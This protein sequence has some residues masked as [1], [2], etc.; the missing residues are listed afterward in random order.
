MHLSLLCMC[1]SVFRSCLLWIADPTTIHRHRTSFLPQ[2]DFCSRLRCPRFTSCFLRR[3]EPSPSPKKHIR[4][5]HS[6]HPFLLPVTG[7]GMGIWCNW[8]KKKREREKF[9]WRAS[10]KGLPHRSRITKE[11]QLLSCGGGCIWVRCANSHSHP[12]ARSDWPIT[13]G[14][15]ADKWKEPDFGDAAESLV[16]PQSCLISSP[17][18]IWHN[19]FSLLFKPAE[20][21][22]SLIWTPNVLTQSIYTIFHL[23]GG[24]E[25]KISEK[26]SR[27]FHTYFF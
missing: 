26:E 18:V 5:C 13:E 2:R 17:P 10:R 1:N 16:Q 7:L 23:G 22:F 4:S 6:W 12:A 8:T 27:A 24:D 25:A 19:T 11:K 9:C 15:E 21:G 3:R 20:S 14:Q